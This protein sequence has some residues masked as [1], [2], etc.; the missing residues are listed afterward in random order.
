[1]HRARSGQHHGLRTL[2]WGL[3]ILL[4]IGVVAVPAPAATPC[5]TPPATFPTS[6]M[7]PGMTG[8]GYTVI[9]GTE[10]QSFDVRVL[11]VL[12]DA[13]YLGIDVVVVEMTGPAGFVATTGGV[14][15]GMSGSPV[16]IDGKLAGAVAWAVA[17]DRHI[18]GLTAAEDMMDLF[19]AAT[20]RS[21]AAPTE[22]TLTDDVRLAI[23]RSTGRSLRSA[24]TTM[25]ALPIPVGVSGAGGRTLSRIED[26]FAA[27]GVHVEAFRSAGAAAPTPA[28]LDPAPLVA[29]GGF[30]MGLSYGDVSEYGFGTTTAVCG[31]V[32]IG[33]G[34][35]FT[36]AG[37]V[38]FGLNDVSI[39]A[40]DS[41]SSW[42]TK[43]GVL[44]DA[45]GTMTQDRFAGV[46]GV[47]GVLPT[48]VPIDSDFTDVDTGRSRTGRTDVAWDEGWYVADVAVRHG[49]ANV[50]S[51]LQADA[52]GTL[53]LA[54]TIDGERED[55]TPFS[56][57][58]GTMRYSEGA[59]AEG[60]YG[61]SD[62]LSALLDGRFGTVTFTGIEMTGWVTERDLTSTITRVRVAS[63]LQPKLKE[64][65]TVKAGPGDEVV[66]EVTFA[67][68]DGEHVVARTGFDV[69]RDAEGTSDVVLRGGRDR[70][71]RPDARSFEALLGALNGGEHPND[72]IV[73]APGG[74]VVEEQ[75]VIVTGQ[76]RFALRVIR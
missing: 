73:S 18:F 6:Q 75:D 16:Y 36:A 76:A 58:N 21:G 15:A 34:H 49:W 25:D 44:T 39:V 3:S 60:V 46:A 28:T 59:A 1:M 40:I 64:R 42:G 50:S 45:H 27:H 22:V 38:A 51:L 30:G 19:R 48:L 55:G 69:A 12:P 74:Q 24:P 2:T 8:T 68:A 13:Y 35:P 5:G 11:G 63:D 26:R 10:I 17:S 52:P 37:A 47:F 43:I 70:H 14:V 4:L 29:G 53:K 66:I 65:R 56:V 57:S 9:Q 31:S 62:T 7:T 23:A 33:W 41:G 20:E 72:L 71:G 54:W 67:T 61:L 32:A